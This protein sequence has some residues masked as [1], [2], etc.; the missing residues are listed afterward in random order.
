MPGQEDGLWEATVS[1]LRGFT[2]NQSN[3]QAEMAQLAAVAAEYKN[4]QFTAN[5][6]EAFIAEY[7][8]KMEQ[9]GIQTVVDEVNRQ[10]EEWKAAK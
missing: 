5:D 4:G 10:I 9:A 3:V 6:I 8:E 2:F 1:S 7:Q